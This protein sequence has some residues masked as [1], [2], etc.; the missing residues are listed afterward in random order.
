[1]TKWK[2]LLSAPVAA[3]M[4]LTMPL[5]TGIANAIADGGTRINHIDRQSN[6]GS[7]VAGIAAANR[8]IKSGDEFVDAAETVKAVGM[9][10]DAQILVMKVFGSGGGAYDSDYFAA[11]EDAL[12]LEADAANLSLGSS[13]PG[14]TYA[15]ATYQRC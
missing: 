14:F 15:S 12:V 9:A 3:L 1:M 4:L 13:A 7:H 6:H 5:T 2:Q 11:I 8:F 10:P